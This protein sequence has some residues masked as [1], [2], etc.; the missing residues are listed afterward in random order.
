[1][2]KTTCTSPDSNGEPSWVAPDGKPGPG[3]CISFGAASVD[4]VV[5]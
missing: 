1:M 4:V 5:S 2:N 3:A